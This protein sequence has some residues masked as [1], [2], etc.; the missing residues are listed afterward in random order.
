MGHA[1]YDDPVLEHEKVWIREVLTSGGRVS[2]IA[3]DLG[4]SKS[5]VLR[6]ANIMGLPRPVPGRPRKETKTPQAEACGA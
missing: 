4:R 6:W 2:Q 5:T 3:T 1:R